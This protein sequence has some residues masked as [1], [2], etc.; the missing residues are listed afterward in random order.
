MILVEEMAIAEIVN[1][2][3]VDGLGATS[4]ASR[5]CFTRPRVG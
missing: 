2:A 4:C 1:F 3:H 5:T